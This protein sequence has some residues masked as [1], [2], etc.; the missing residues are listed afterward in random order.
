MIAA[1]HATLLFFTLS[2]LSSSAWFFASSSPVAKLDKETLQTT[3]D[4]IITD[5]TVRQFNAQGH[6]ANQL[7]TPRLHHIPKDDSHWLETPHIKVSKANQPLW[8]I[9][10]NKAHVLY[11]GE[12]I[13]FLN[14]VK[15]HQPSS[16]DNPETTL[17]TEELSYFPKLQIATTL[18]EIVFERPGSLVKAKG[19]RA[20]FAKGTVQ[21]LDNVRLTYEAPHA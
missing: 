7:H 11:G 15:I 12:Q 10:A 1:R 21:L 6:L 16:P 9:Q 19:V 5:L 2:V 4:I 14:H 18:K 13:T 3:P 17:T 8:D 20:D